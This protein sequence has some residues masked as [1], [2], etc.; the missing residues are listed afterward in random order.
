MSVPEA[1]HFK[2]RRILLSIIIACIN[3]T[4]WFRLI[5]DNL[6]NPERM[7]ALLGH[8]EEVVDIDL[9]HSF[10]ELIM[11]FEITDVKLF[12]CDLHAEGTEIISLL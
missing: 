4:T 7:T 2:S 5:S 3:P 9:F 10:E 12:L 6:T 8:I 1:I 11:H